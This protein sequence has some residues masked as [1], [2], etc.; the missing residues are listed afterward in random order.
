[1][2]KTIM[3][4]LLY[5]WPFIFLKSP[6]EAFIQPI[7]PFNKHKSTLCSTTS[8]MEGLKTVNSFNSDDNDVV[9]VIGAGPAGLAATLKLLKIG[10]KVNVFDR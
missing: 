5:I 3:R 1:M 9:S 4:L 7:S 8:A 2:S 10:K 6:S